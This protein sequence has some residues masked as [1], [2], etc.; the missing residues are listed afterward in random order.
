MRTVTFTLLLIDSTRPLE[1][2]SSTAAAM[3]ALRRRT[4]FSTATTG[5]ILQ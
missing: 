1:M 3:S 5:L 4:F 2:P